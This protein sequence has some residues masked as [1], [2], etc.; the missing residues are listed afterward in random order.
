MK[1]LRA[2][3]SVSLGAPLRAVVRNELRRV[4]LRA[5]PR[6]MHAYALLAEAK[7]QGSHLTAEDMFR[8]MLEIGSRISLS[9]V[10]RMLSDFEIA[11][12][13]ERQRFLKGGVRFELASG[14]SHSHLIDEHTGDIVEFRAEDFGLQLGKI[15]A[16]YGCEVE[17]FTL[18]IYITRTR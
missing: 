2:P 13:I 10:Y 8:G 6:R 15:A 12:L 3:K 18:S 11:G 9:T 5:T 7:E 17:K 1:R 16:H 14:D 4:G